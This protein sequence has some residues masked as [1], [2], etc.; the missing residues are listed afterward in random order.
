[1]DNPQEPDHP[2]KALSQGAST[3]SLSLLLSLRSQ[4]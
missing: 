2:E 1:M 4:N 3:S